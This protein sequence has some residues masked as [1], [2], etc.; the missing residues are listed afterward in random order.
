M[1]APEAPLSRTG[2]SV[3]AA[4]LGIIFTLGFLNNFL[5]LMLFTRFHV[6]RTPINL[7]L[8]NISVSDM[9]VCVFGT[10]FSFAASVRGRWLIGAHG[11]RWYG[12]A[13]T[14]FGVV[15]L[16][17]LAIL[18]YE[19][20]C[21]TLCGSRVGVLNHR[22]VRM[23]VVGC[24]VYSL[25]WTV[26]PLF[27][28]S[29]YGPEGPGTTCS[30]RWALRT[31]GSRAYI[32]CLFVFCL[33]LPLLTIIFCYGKILA[34]VYGVR[35]PCF[36]Q[37]RDERGGDVFEVWLRAVCVRCVYRVRERG[38]WC[39]VCT[40]L[41]ERGWWWVGCVPSPGAV[42]PTASI[43]PSVLAKSSTVLNPVIYV[44]FDKQFYR[45]FVAL[46]TCGSESPSGYMFRT[47]PISCA[48]SPAPNGIALGLYREPSLPNSLE[49]T[50]NSR[51]P[52]MD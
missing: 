21:S 27:G 10:P 8:L 28:W 52:T 34:T 5:V 11:C 13:N 3:V 51:T 19:R 18:S 4:C 42:S 23:S 36:L 2:H 7:L 22:K 48:A 41:R 37:P 43:V 12:F 35:E 17:S 46:V 50:D 16:A 26:P 40:E 47:K 44:L 32:I 38:V 24:W 1:A 49:L 45:C 9:L 25:I 30:V 33:I 14:L 6:L 31:P 15:S 20:Y 39:E 29:G